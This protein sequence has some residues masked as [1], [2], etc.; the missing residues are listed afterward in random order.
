MT[1]A[2]TYLALTAFSLV[3]PLHAAEPVVDPKRDL[4]RFPA[5]EPKDALKTFAVKNG[6]R[7][8]LVASEPL[9]VDP[10]AM[11]FDENGRLFVVEMRDYSERRDEKPHL[12]TIRL[13]EDTDGDGRFDKG[14]VFADD[15]PWPTGVIC[16]N[17][18]IFVAASPDVIWFKDTNGDGK[19]D[20]RK[21]VFTGYGADKDR[22]NVQALLNSFN[23][24]IDNRIHGATGPNG[25]GSVRNLMKPDSTPI[26]LGRFDFRFDPKNWTLESELGGGQYG[27]SFD[28]RGRKFVSSNSHHL[29][30]LMYDGRYAN[31][32]AAYNLPPALVDIPID[33]PAAEVYRRSPEEPWRV[34]RTKWR[35]SGA[36]KGVVEGGGRASGYFTGATGATI[37]RG[38]AFPKEF[39]NNAF[40][41]DAGGNLIHRKVVREN[42]VEIIAERAADEQKIEFIASTDTWFR[43]VQ[44]FNAPDGCLYVADMYREVIEHPWSLPESMKKY[45]DLNSGNDRGRIYRITPANFKQPKPVRL[46]KATTAEL[47]NMLTH[48]NGWHRET[49]ARLLYE[50]QDRSA[51]GVLESIAAT[52]TIPVARMHA[53]HTLEGLSILRPEILLHSLRDTD[54]TVRNH[55]IQLSEP[56]CQIASNAAL[57]DRLVSLASDSDPQVRYQLAFTLGEFDHPKRVEALAAIA[58]RD[59]GSTWTRAA[60]FSSLSRDA[61]RLFSNLAAQPAFRDT[62]QGR[63]WLQDLT[64]LIATQN[65][66]GTLDTVMRTLKESKDPLLSFG[67]VRSLGDGLQRSRRTFRDVDTDGTVLEVFDRARAI[68][69]DSRT[70][71][72]TRVQAV[73]A[74]GLTSFGASSES[75]LKLLSI[76]Q[77]Q[78]VQLAALASLDRFTDTT[79]GPELTK[80]W[81]DYGARVRIEV[82]AILLKRTDRSLALMYA[83]TSGTIRPADLTLS[84]IRQLQTHRDFRITELAA[85]AFEGMSA[86]KRD[87]VM[88]NFQPAIDLNGDTAK[89]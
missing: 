40:I 16:Y 51:I 23:W 79:L 86:G 54:A 20:E 13:L 32:N 63:Q 17:G 50:R 42:G 35:V 19:A 38:N 24:G 83:I 11:S 3:L 88:K 26:N 27:L 89:G 45:I 47:A 7:M 43:P 34:L 36:V 53:L 62:E 30:A 29:Q 85:K 18:G 56:L 59:I 41:G 87:E 5:V 8:D 33:G 37:Y 78:T 22:L 39:L 61:D 65:H 71:E 82:L 48:P 1:R 77:P 44:F 84:Q 72:A 69:T 64:Q 15:L 81:R 57:R 46:G 68:A 49:A 10:I 9:V 75:L 14:T 25:G 31:R 58:A 74:L 12:G 67:L 76:E 70:N 2:T 80:R 73:Q 28:T 66:P 55:A 6:F 52:S 60:V 21:T 4:P